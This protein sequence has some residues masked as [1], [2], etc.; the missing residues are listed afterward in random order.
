LSEIDRQAEAEI[1]KN[2]K[3]AYPEHAILA[4]E[5]GQHEGNEYTW[6]IDPLDG[7]TNFLHGFPHYAV[8]TD[9]DSEHWMHSL[10]FNERLENRIA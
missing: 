8:S 9:S 6:I 10:N 2:I 3:T 4:E 5:S 7:T 1:I